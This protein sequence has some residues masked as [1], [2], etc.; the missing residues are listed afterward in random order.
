MSETVAGTPRYPCPLE[1]GWYLDVPPPGVGRTAGQTE[2]AI[3]GH[4]DAHTVEEF[5]HVIYDLRVKVAE[6]RRARH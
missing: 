3:R 2:Q 1:C 4:L 5:V 6:L